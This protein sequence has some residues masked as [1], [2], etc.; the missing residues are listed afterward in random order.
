MKFFETSIKGAYLIELDKIEDSRGFFARAFCEKEFKDNRLEFNLAQANIA[1][2]EKK[3]TLRGMHYQICSA[4][5][6]K[7]F[8]CIQG[9]ILDVIVDLRPE[10]ETYCQYF[11]TELSAEKSSMLYIP[12]NLAHGYLTLEDNSS[13]FYMVSE[14][15]TPD[16]CAA[17]R[18]NDPYFN[19]NWPI[20]NPTLSDADKSI[21]NF[22]P[23]TQIT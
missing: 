10:S 11:K 17:V 23:I 18:W 6:I 13:V 19:I 15:Y 2:T 9:K 16:L 21:P 22:E 3:G 20:N 5:E 8:R 7:I 1:H 4:A 12:Q 14:P